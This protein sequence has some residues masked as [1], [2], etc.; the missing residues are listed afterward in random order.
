MLWAGKVPDEIIVKDNVPVY[1]FADIIKMCHVRSCEYLKI[2]TE[3]HDVIIL[4]SY[5]DCV[6]EGFPLIPKI[7]FEANE[8]IPQDQVDA[9]LQK[10]DAYGYTHART[11]DGGNIILN[12]V[13]SAKRN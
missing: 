10:L 8:W 5:L 7:Q 12:L 13:V 11:S 2:D 1:T 6:S 4:Q 3:G 9:I